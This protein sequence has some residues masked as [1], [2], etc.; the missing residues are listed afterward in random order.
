MKAYQ[1]IRQTR[2]FAILLAFVLTLALWPAWALAS[3]GEAAMP[4]DPDILAQGALL[5]DLKTGKMVYGKNEHEELYPASLT[6]IMTA[7]L[8]LEAI[9]SGKLGF[10]K[11]ITAGPIVNTL[12]ADGSTVGIKEGEVMTVRNLLDCLLIP[13]AN[14]AACVLAITV[15][16]TIDAF[17]DA[18]NKKAAELGCQNTHFVNPH[19]LHDPGHYTSP[20]D[21]YLITKAAMQY[22]TFM[23][24]CDTDRVV[25]PAT[26]KSQ[27]RALL[28][29]N[30]LICN[31][32][33]PDYKNP[34]VHGVKTGSTSQSGHCLVATA[35]RNNKRFLSVVMGAERVQEGKRTV[36]RSFSETTRLF[37]WGFDNFRY[38]TLLDE[39][40]P[41][42]EVPVELSKTDHVTAVAGSSLEA[43][44]PAG[45]KKD[46]L[47]RT[48]HLEGDKLEAPIE[49]GQKLGTVTVSY[50]GVEY[51]TAD[52]IS[53]HSA[54]LSKLLQ[55][56]KQIKDL[57]QKPTTWA[58]AGV[59]G[60]ALMAI[61]IAGTIRSRR[62]AKKTGFSGYNGR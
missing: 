19:G 30:Y 50:D 5:V 20:W 42:D 24:I 36:I 2:V 9:D 21:M 39:S 57:A 18:M 8:T 4:P 45:I 6:K 3:E 44:L 53:S 37:N 34:E 41:I 40:E 43:L 1:K 33:I 25:I 14:E 48:I 15:S 22:P 28:N 55:T 10:Q 13:S 59:A 12:P 26:N 23:V 16:G 47:K 32:R 35:E 17:V 56:E 49:E 58:I 61:A 7:L 46:M 60:A 31:R 11:E 52:L 38:M 62:R 51:G 54:E 29:T 27:E